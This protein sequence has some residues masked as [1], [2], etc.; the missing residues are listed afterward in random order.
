M[1]PIE[2]A[3]S[4]QFQP[5]NPSNTIIGKLFDAYGQQMGLDRDRFF[6]YSYDHQARSGHLPSSITDNIADGNADQNTPMALVFMQRARAAQNDDDTQTSLDEQL[7]QQELETDQA[8]VL[9]DDRRAQALS[10]SQ[11]L[12]MEPKAESTTDEGTFG[13]T[14]I[15]N[16]V[17][18][19]RGPSQQPLSV[20]RAIAQKAQYKVGM[21]R[22]F[23]MPSDL[24]G[25]K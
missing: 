22:R 15:R 17:L 18:N 5:Y 14:L 4:F 19:K 10:E 12:A 3:N 20:M 9:E 7:A 2:V 8:R 23:Q 1:Q 24:R 6:Q 25:R 16:S 21:Q 11:R 13:Q